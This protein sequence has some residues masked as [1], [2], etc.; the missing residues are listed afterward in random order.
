MQTSSVDAVN[1]PKTPGMGMTGRVNTVHP[2][3]LPQC[4]RRIIKLRKDAIL[5]QQ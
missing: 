3:H 4:G 1:A 5:R 2:K